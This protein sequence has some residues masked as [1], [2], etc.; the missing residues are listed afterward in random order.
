MFELNQVARRW[1]RERLNQLGGGSPAPGVVLV[2]C[3]ASKA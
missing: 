1:R 2:Y 3:I